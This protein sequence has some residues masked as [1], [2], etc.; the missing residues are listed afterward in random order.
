MGFFI[1][2]VACVLIVQAY[3]YSKV[4]KIGGLANDTTFYRHQQFAS[5]STNPLLYEWTN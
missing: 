4:T 5:I 3:P 1:K 2:I